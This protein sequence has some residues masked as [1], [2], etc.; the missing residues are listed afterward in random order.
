[1]FTKNVSWLRSSVSIVRCILDTLE[2]SG[3]YVWI[4]KYYIILLRPTD[5]WLVHRYVESLLPS[6]FRTSLKV[7]QEL[8]N[9]VFL[10][11]VKMFE[12][13][14]IIFRFSLKSTN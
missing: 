11:F 5:I 7:L 12:I 1:M 8:L 14:E 2:L 13:I 6:E 4:A 3:L 9:A 10:I